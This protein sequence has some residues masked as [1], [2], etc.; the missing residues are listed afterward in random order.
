MI[1]PRII[2][3]LLLEYFIMQFGLRFGK[4]VMELYINFSCNSK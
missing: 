3:I 4:G 2:T 1:Y